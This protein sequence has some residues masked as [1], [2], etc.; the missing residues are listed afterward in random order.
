[1]KVKRVN[2]YICEYCKKS[3]C[4]AGHMKKHEERCTMNPNRK[5]GMCAMMDLDQP[6]LTSM[7]ALL[8]NPD[9]YEKKERYWSGFGNDFKKVVEEIMPKLRE[10][11][12]DCPACILAALRQAKIPVRLV[13]SFSFFE[14]CKKTWEDFNEKRNW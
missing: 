7:I 3:G 14:E 13:E 12:N 11:T 2:R 5:C 10:K 1:M 8:P 9:Q 6:N 4:A